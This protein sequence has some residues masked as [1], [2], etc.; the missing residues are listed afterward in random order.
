MINQ[1]DLEIH[2][3]GKENIIKRS[4]KNVIIKRYFSE[5]AKAWSRGIDI[6]FIDGSQDYE[7]VKSDFEN[8]SK[9]VKPNWVIL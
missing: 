7:G 6:L 2:K 1:L 3:K 9:Y 5:I 8:W 4:V